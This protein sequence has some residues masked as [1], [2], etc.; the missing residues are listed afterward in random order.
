LIHTSQNLS[1]GSMNN[2]GSGS[3]AFAHFNIEG[4]PEWTIDKAVIED[5]D[6]VL[7]LLKNFSELKFK[8]RLYAAREV[9]FLNSRGSCPGH[10][11]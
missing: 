10:S 9:D 2:G 1:T 5:N 7:F 6:G 4:S 3:G 8:T 11:I